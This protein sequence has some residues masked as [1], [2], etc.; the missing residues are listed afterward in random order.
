VKIIVTNDDGP[1]TP[2]LKPL[3]EALSSQGHDLIVV[4]PERPRSAAG[5]A[6]T[7]HKPLRIKKLGDIYVING[8]PADAVFL[9]L[10][11]IAPDAELVFSGVNVGENIGV[12][13]T[14][15]SGTVGAAIQGG[16]MGVRSIAMSMELGGDL[17]VVKKVAAAAVDVVNHGLGEAFTI[18]I[19]IPREW[20]G[21]VYCAKRLAKSVYREELYEGRDPR[22]DKFYWRWGPRREVFE[23]DTDAYYFYIQR[24][25]TVVG[26]SDRGLADVGA[27]G[28]ALAER[29]GVKQI[30]C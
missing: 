12:E 13:A 28:R 6:R 1:H 15:G 20:R 27:Y 8:Y 14:Y 26:I 7:Y 23:P 22:D 21:V 5:L 18:S 2:L 19:N 11:L 10:K 16:V 9:A 24:G 25:V 29:L 4:V 30:N 3:L 17:D